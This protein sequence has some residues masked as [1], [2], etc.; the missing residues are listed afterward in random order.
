MKPVG[1]TKSSIDEEDRATATGTDV[2]LKEEARQLAAEEEEMPVADCG[3]GGG[4]SRVRGPW[5][6]EE[7]AVLTGLVAKFGARNW[8]LIARGIPGRSGKSCRLRWCNQLDP[9]VKRKP[10]N[11]EEDLIIIKAHALHGNKWAAIAKLLPGRTD[12]AIKNH[13]NSTLRRKGIG[14]GRSQTRPTDMMEDS[15]PVETN[16][17]SEETMSAEDSQSNRPQ[18]GREIA[19]ENGL[20]QNET[21]AQRRDGLSVAET[22]HNTVSRPQPRVSAFRIYKPER[23]SS[24]GSGFSK[25]MHAQGPSMLAFK[26][27]LVAHNFLDDAH[28]DL[29][30]PPHCGYGCCASPT[31]LHSESSLLG[32]DFVDYEEPPSYS[33]LDLMSVALDLN[34]TAWIKTGLVNSGSQIPETGE[35]RRKCQGDTGSSY[36]GLFVPN[37]KT[38]HTRFE[39]GKDK[40]A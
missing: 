28:E 5:S 35:F 14:L 21:E 29:K 1:G 4:G 18:D 34:N 20:K 40:L 12:N 7:D 8:S 26:T 24:T 10:F 36:L 38:E 16:A 15:W 17:S 31:G 6:P 33:T 11:D 32:P 19:I 22:T 13:W 2:K 23:N 30:I 39:E 3:G 37:K 9:S 25:D 27:E